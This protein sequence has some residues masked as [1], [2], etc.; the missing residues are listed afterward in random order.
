VTHQGRENLAQDNSIHTETNRQRYIRL[1][2]I[3]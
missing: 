2:F 3:I 1:E